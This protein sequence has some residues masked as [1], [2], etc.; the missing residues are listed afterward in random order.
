M[1]HYACNLQYQHIFSV[2]LKLA[3][4]ESG[5]RISE[6]S[7]LTS[8]SFRCSHAATYISSF[9]WYHIQEADIITILSFFSEST[10]VLVPPY[11][12]GRDPKYFSPASNIFW[13]DRW[14]PNPDL[15]SF[16]LSASSIEKG[17]VV[18]NTTAFI[19]FSHGPTHCA[20]KNLALMEMRMV[21]ALMLQRFEMRFADG[22]DPRKWEAGLEDYFIVMNGKLPVVLTSRA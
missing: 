11:V 4:E 12:I 3:Q 7:R 1:K 17:P 10:A 13:P 15:T 22:Y 20:G 21:V 9:H 19:P 2:R 6:Y 5:S 18:T 8:T 16:P 14:L